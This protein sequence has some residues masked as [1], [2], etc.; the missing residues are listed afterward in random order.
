MRAKNTRIGY[1]GQGGGDATLQ[2]RMD[3]DIAFYREARKQGLQPSGS[4]RGAVERAF[5]I[6]DVT[7]KPWRADKPELSL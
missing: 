6:S 2:K 3:S 5:E 7:G 4:T 1:C